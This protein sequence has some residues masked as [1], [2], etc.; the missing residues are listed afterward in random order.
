[1]Q[2]VV[3]GFGRALGLAGVGLNSVPEPSEDHVLA[4]AGVVEGVTTRLLVLTGAI[5]STSEG[6]GEEQERQTPRA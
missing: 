1:M 6:K 3:V 2:E 5:L 4:M